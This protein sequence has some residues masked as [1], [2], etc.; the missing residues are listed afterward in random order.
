MRAFFPVKPLKFSTRILMLLAA[1][2]SALAATPADA[3]PCTNPDDRA[4]D[5]SR[6]G[7]RASTV[8]PGG[9]YSSDPKMGTTA[10]WCLTS[11]IRHLY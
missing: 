3:G 8:R 9:K 11:S 4:A 1:F 6:C 5:G 2:A 7:G 10:L